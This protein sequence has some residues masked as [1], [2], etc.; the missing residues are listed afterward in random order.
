MAWDVAFDVRSPHVRLVLIDTLGAEHRVAYSPRFRVRPLVLTR[1][2]P[3]STYQ[4]FDIGRHAF[5]SGNIR[6]QLFPD[7]W[8]A[9]PEFTYSPLGSDPFRGGAGYPFWMPLPPVHAERADFPDWP[10]YVGVFGAEALYDADGPRFGEVAAMEYQH[11]LL[12]WLVLR[13]QPRLAD[14]VRG[15]RSSGCSLSRARFHRRQPLLGCRAAQRQPGALRVVNRTQTWQTGTEYDAVEA[16]AQGQ[17]VGK[18]IRDLQAQLRS[19][20]GLAYRALSIREFDGTR[21]SGAHSL[22]PTEVRELTASPGRFNI[23]V[24]DSNHP[25]DDSHFIRVD[26]L[27]GGWRYDDPGIDPDDGVWFGF[28]PALRLV[29]PVEAVFENATLAPLRRSGGGGLEIAATP[30][31]DVRIRDAQ[32]RTS[33]FAGNLL[34][35]GIPGAIPFIPDTGGPSAPLRTACP[36]VLTASRSPT[37]RAR[38]SARP[39]SRRPATCSGSPTR[40]PRLRAWTAWPMTLR[41]DSARPTWAGRLGR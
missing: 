19:D 23:F 37:H 32:G 36:P 18:V 26:T 17:T 7:V 10:S 5:A 1:V 28:G 27:S 41:R 24:Y 38:R 15:S 3:D 20:N 2:R 35:D 25:L 6:S 13:V 39:S 14:G 16:A 4:I 31:A 12:G 22:L 30:F 11:G 21:G 29:F 40:A 34:L 33:G 9:R 8:Q